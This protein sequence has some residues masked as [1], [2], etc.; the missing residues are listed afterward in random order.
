MQIIRHYALKTALASVLLLTPLLAFSP[1][2]VNSQVSAQVDP[3]LLY[4]HVEYLAKIPRPPA[5]ETEFAAGV[6]IEITLRSYGYQTKLQPFTYYSYRK[7]TTLSLQVEGVPGVTWSLH[8]FTYAPNGIASGMV[9]AC[10]E[11]TAADFQ[12]TDVQGKIALVKRGS[13]PYSEKVR[14]AAAAGAAGL[15]IQND[16][17]QMWKGSLGAPLDMAV[18]VVGISKSQGE[19]LRAKMN[20]GGAMATMK[21]DGALTL[22]HTSYSILANRPATSDNRGQVVLLAARHDSLANSQGA[23]QGAS[24]VAVMLEAARILAEQP[25]DTD[26]QLVSFGA[27]TAGNQGA[28]SFVKSL[29]EREK[30]KIVAAIVLDALGKK[31]AGQLVATSNGGAER[32][33]VKLIQE[34]GVQVISGSDTA[35]FGSTQI[36]FGS[37]VPTAFLTR[38]PGKGQQPDTPESVSRE[39][40]A[41]ATQALLDA[42]SPITDPQS[43]AYPKPVHDNLPEWKDSLDE[44][45]Q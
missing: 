7:P 12:Q 27:S 30:S 26:I 34:A 9:V 29:G 2:V 28:R 23:D 37:D 42:V 8:G 45:V 25:S 10:G 22:R 21:V 31:D 5:T 18:P 16:R 36:L 14:Q 11:G 3:D 38:Q 33:P 17:D 13:L 40:L 41:E 19:L 15:I 6:Y 32:L 35:V 39:H 44:E 1:T 43:P 24:G 20:Q 4:E